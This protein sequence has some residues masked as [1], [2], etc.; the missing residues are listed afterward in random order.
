MKGIKIY[1]KANEKLYVNGAVIQVDRK[2][3]L[4]LLNN[5]TFLLENHVLQAKDA[6]TPFRQLYFVVQ[7]MMM[8]PSDTKGPAELFADLAA[9]LRD[10]LETP[11]LQEGLDRI[12]ADVRDGNYFRALKTIRNLLPMEDRL[13]AAKLAMAKPEA[14]F[15][16]AR[17]MAETMAQ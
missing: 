1:L 8:E 15:V 4:E 3:A 17:K 12:E 7:V 5:A 11:E 13:L 9:S 2:V 14:A 10:A 16:A 6:T